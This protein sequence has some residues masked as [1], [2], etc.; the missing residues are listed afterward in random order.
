[1]IKKHARLSVPLKTEAGNEKGG[2]RTKS[3]FMESQEC[4]KEFHEIRAFFFS[5]V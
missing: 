4:G 3:T 5:F 2:R 1:M